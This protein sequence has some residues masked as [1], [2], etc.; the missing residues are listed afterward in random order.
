MKAVLTV[1]D[2][3]ID[4]ELTEQQQVTINEATMTGF[5]HIKSY[6]DACKSQHVV[7]AKKDSRHKKAYKKLVKIIKAINEGWEP[8]WA[9][10]S[11]LKWYPVFD[12]NPSKEADPSGVGLAFP[13]ADYW[14]AYANVGARLAYKDS[15]R[16]EYGAKQFLELYSDL[17]VIKQS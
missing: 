5:E 2:K 15:E 8:N 4:L 11:Q 13:Y 16:A 17:Y 3:A 10:S 1:G 14:Y 6:E 9:D 7:K 12:M